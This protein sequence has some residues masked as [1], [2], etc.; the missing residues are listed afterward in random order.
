[1]PAVYGQMDSEEEPISLERFTE[2]LQGVHRR[3]KAARIVLEADEDRGELQECSLAVL[4]EVEECLGI[5]D[6]D[7]KDLSRDHTG[8]MWIHPKV[9]KRVIEVAAAIEHDCMCYRT[10]LEVYV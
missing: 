8:C 3:I 6:S 9:S 1:M 2:Q 10:P 7:A 5:L 4:R